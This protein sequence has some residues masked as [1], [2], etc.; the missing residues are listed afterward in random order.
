MLDPTYS[1][2]R[3][4]LSHPAPA[5]IPIQIVKYKNFYAYRIDLDDFNGLSE[6]K[7]VDFAEWLVARSKIAGR[8]AGTRVTIEWDD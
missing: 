1:I 6:T 4:S 3:D 2:V 8:L 5:K 7:R